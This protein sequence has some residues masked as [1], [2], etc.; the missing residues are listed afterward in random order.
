MPSCRSTSCS[1]AVFPIPRS[2]RGQRLSQR[3]RLPAGPTVG[4]AARWPRCRCIRSHDPS[5]RRHANR[6][7][8]GHHHRNSPIGCCAR[9]RRNWSSASRSV[10]KSSSAKTTSCRRSSKSSKPLPHQRHRQLVAY[11]IHDTFV[12]D[13]I[14]ALMYL[15]LFHDTRARGRRRRSATAGTSFEAGS[16]RRRHARDD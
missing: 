5:F 9:A 1:T 12:Q 7:W 10:P 13:L 2:G 16:P 3:Q 15:D 14:A 6:H 4:C 11:E 8:Q